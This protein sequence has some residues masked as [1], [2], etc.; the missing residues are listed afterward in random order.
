MDTLRYGTPPQERLPQRLLAI[1][2]RY[3]I[4]VARQAEAAVE[5]GNV[6]PVTTHVQSVRELVEEHP[7]GMRSAH[8]HHNL[9]PGR[10]DWLREK[11]M[12]E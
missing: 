3:A 12:I 5:L 6:A 4:D 10:L 7:K 8:V 1:R 9:G 11:G 2:L